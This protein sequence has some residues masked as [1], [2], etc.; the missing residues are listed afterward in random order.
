MQGEVAEARLPDR[1]YRRVLLLASVFLISACGLA[2]EVI[3]ASVSS[4]LIGDAVTQFSLVVGAFLCAMGAG[5][6][7]AKH[8]E[9]DLL[10][11]FVDLEIGVGLVGGVSSI[12]VFAASVYASEIFEVVFYGFCVVIGAMVGAEIPLLVRVLSKDGRDVREALSQTLALDYVGA[13][14]GSVAVPLVALPW[15]GMSRVSVV[16]GLMNLGA[17]ALGLRLVSGKQ[18][19]RKVRLA[20]AFALL[21]AAFAFSPRLIGFFEDQLY[22]DNVVYA[23]STR[24]QRI[25]LTRFRNDVRL[26]LDGHVQFSSIDEARYHEPLVHPA[27]ESVPHPRR[28]LILGGGDGLALREVLRWRS[29]RHV[30]LVDLDPAMTELARTRGELVDLNHGSMRD[31]RVAIRNADALSFVRRDEGFYDVIIA[32]LPDPSSATLAKLYSREFYTAALRRLS[33][34]GAFVTHATSPFYARDAFW[35]IVG[36]LEAAAED[37]PARRNVYA[38]HVNV[39]SFGEWGFALA[40]DPRRDPRPLRSSV[41]TRFLTPDAW[42]AMFAFGRDVLRPEQVEINDLSRPTLHEAYRDAWQSY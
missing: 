22:D 31:R 16:F 26:Y 27:M 19:A 38:Y 30:V 29:V 3:A 10:G 20:I 18:R 32:D 6:Y 8:I 33:A 21:A 2:Y 24:Y 13:L 4:Y 1:D 5:A 17:A 37:G 40:V 11:A 42:Q 14:A 39:P 9:R 34:G 28:V 36:T 35:S 15:L 7:F 12:A 25:V 23:A 41:E